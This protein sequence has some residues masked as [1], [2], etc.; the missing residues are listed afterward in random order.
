M[1]A[2][3]RRPGRHQQV[4]GTKRVEDKRALDL[5]ESRPELDA[6]RIGVFGISMGAIQGV[7]LTAE[8]RRIR[9]AVF[10]LVGEICHTFCATAPNQEL[11]SAESKVLREHNLTQQQLE[12][13]AAQND[14]LRAQ[15]GCREN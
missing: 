15:Y 12:D 9:A 5:D 6:A 14:H 3:A 11:R 2:R 13:E 10:G 7:L 1:R 4:G 8:D